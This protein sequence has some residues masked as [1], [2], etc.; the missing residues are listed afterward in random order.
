[1]LVE[2]K[3]TAVGKAQKPWALE[4]TRLRECCRFVGGDRLVLFFFPF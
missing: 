1:M 4:G 2:G 3:F